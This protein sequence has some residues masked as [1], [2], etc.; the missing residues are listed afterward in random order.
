MI[1]VV[2]AAGMGSRSG[3]MKQLTPVGP[4][5]E[6]IMDYTIY[7]AIS[8][9]V[10]KVVFVIKEDFKEEFIKTIGKRIEEKVKVE[11]SCQKGFELSDDDET[12]CEKTIDA[13]LND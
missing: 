8:C 1:L 3:G 13:K 4:N 6:L 5:N 9:G 12:K 10:D 11:Y 2:M 7:D